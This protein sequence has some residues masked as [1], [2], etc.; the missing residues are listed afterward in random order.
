MIDDTP[1]YDV[2]NA[3]Y[4]NRT[5][6][7]VI[8]TALE[9]GILEGSQVKLNGL[10]MECISQGI[11]QLKAYPDNEKY[12]Y[13]VLATPD[14]F[15]LVFNVGIST[16]EHTYVPGLLGA[17]PYVKEDPVKFTTHVGTS[18]IL[19]SYAG[20]LLSSVPLMILN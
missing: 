2:T 18:A 5:G 10:N 20:G 1:E 16:I 3:V 13:R 4:T 9:T 14:D 19:H 15:T 12:R 8:T 7:L 11:L 17:N 6:E